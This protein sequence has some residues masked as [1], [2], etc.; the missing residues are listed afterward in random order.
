MRKS[1]A[2]RMLSITLFACAVL[3][4]SCGT[5]YWGCRCVRTC[6]GS[7]RTGYQ[8]VCTDQEDLKLALS[9]ATRTCEQVL[10]QE[11]VTYSCGCNCFEAWANCI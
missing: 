7:I 11:C 2:A 5:D 4:A 1:N 6:D 10:S 9:Y 8:D 3:L